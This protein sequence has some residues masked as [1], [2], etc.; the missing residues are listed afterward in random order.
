MG[1]D[2]WLCRRKHEDEENDVEIGYWRKFNALHGFITAMKGGYE[3]CDS[4]ELSLDELQEIKDVFIEVQGLL[5]RI[6]ETDNVNEKEALYE[7]VTALL[8]PISGFFFGSHE[9][10]EWYEE[11]VNDTIPI[12]DAAIELVEQG[13]VVYYHAWW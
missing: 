9:I 3:D 7:E 8:P 10:D 4:V 2:M 6:H 13:E 1:L 5:K 12:V 11:D